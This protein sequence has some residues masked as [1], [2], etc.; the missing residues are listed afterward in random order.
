MKQ[1]AGKLGNQPLLLKENDHGMGWKNTAR[2]PDRWHLQVRTAQ[3]AMGARLHRPARSGDQVLRRGSRSQGRSAVAREQDHLGHRPADRH[4]GLHRR[5]LFGDHQGRAHRR[6]RLLQLGRLLGRRAEDGRL[7]HD[8]LRGQVG[9]A[10][11][12]G[13][14]GRQGRTARCRLHLGQVGVG[15]RAGDQGE[16]SGTADARQQHRARG[17]D[18]LP[19]CRGRQRPA[20]R[21]RALRRGRGDGQQEPEGDRGARHQ[22]R[23]QH[24]RFQGVHAGDH[25]G[26]EGPARQRRHR[27]G[28][29]DLSAP[30]C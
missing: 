2:Q 19:V 4:D 14:R 24:P 27:P 7:G 18:R 28:P 17:R 25:G 12:P 3:H 22:G 23:G 29:A 26:E 9:Q 16:A 15:D 13:D 20:S 5:A 21:R 11:V 10:G 30:R 8:H 1:W 6:D